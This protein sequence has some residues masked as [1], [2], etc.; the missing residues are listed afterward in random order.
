[1]TY[2]RATKGLLNEHRKGLI[3]TGLHAYGVMGYSEG[4]GDYVFTYLVPGLDESS[5]GDQTLHHLQ[6]PRLGCEE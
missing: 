5:L 3:G 2:P 1:M 4:Y 6:A